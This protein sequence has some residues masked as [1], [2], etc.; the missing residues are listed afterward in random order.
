MWNVRPAQLILL[1]A[2]SAP[3]SLA[4]QVEVRTL[5][6][7]LVLDTANRVHVDLSF[8]DVT[9]EGV[10]RGALAEV[11]LVL[12]CSREDMEACKKRA[13]RVQLAPRTRRGELQIRLKRTSRARL[14]GIKARLKVRMP[15][16][17]PLEVDV[18]SGKIYLSGLRSHIDVNSGGGDVDILGRE[19]RT[20]LVNVDLGFG[21]A[22][23]WVG[24]GRVKGSGWP[25]S[26][27]W[28]G[29]GQAEIHVDVIGQGDV[30]IRLE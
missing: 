5:Q 4:A 12:E 29:S 28:A 20:R 10:K 14:R 13:N 17:L 2:L 8:G 6:Q 19:K 21:S 26:I 3:H 15:R 23:L 9:I 24:G 18:N 7:E 30:S 11:E 16:D 1:A 27:D 25:R 22:D